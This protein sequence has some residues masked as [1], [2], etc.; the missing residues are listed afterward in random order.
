VEQTV[1]LVSS[2]KNSTAVVAISKTV[3]C[4]GENV[5]FINVQPQKVLN[6]AVNVRS[7][8]VKL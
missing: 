7:Y 5:T 6:I 3:R 8:L 1:L 2:K 4:F